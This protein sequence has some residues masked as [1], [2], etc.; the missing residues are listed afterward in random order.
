MQKVKNIILDY[1]NVIF[2]IDFQRVKQAFTALGVANVDEVF[3]HS[4]QIALFDDFDKGKISAQE[5]RDG[6]RTLANKPMLTDSEVDQ[7]WN[8]LLIGVP[9][10]KH[11]LLERLNEKYRTFLLSNNN[12]IHYAYCMDHIEQTYG[13]KD[14]S[15]FFEKTYYSHLMG[16]RKPDSEIFEKVLTENELVPHETLF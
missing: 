5:F 10:G 14:N 9:A 11:E 4:G 7:A 16:M 1:G 3:A 8:A 12:E 2:M 6:L 13:V 15:Q